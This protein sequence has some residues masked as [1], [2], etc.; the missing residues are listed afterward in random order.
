MR[1]NTPPSSRPRRRRRRLSRLAGSISRWTARVRRQTDLTQPGTDLLALPLARTKQLR[2]WPA[3]REYVPK[4]VNVFVLSTQDRTIRTT[5]GAHSIHLNTEEGEG[6]DTLVAK[7]S[8]RDRQF[9]IELYAMKQGFRSP[10]KTDPPRKN[11]PANLIAEENARTRARSL[12]R[13]C[14]RRR[15]ELR[16]QFRKFL[17]KRHNARTICKRESNAIVRV[18]VPS[19]RAVSGRLI[20]DP[21]FSLCFNIPTE[22]GSRDDAVLEVTQTAKHL[23]I[24][25]A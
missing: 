19:A 8:A 13:V 21:D 11:T 20:S 6:G 23:E 7:W 17:S 3:R 22:G 9:Q 1:G 16:P 5:G 14:V 10:R 24:S 12:A 4:C 25:F 15:Q 2:F 18:S